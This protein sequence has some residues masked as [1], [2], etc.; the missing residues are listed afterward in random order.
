MPIIQLMCVIVMMVMLVI[1]AFCVPATNLKRI[2]VFRR[3]RLCPDHS[4]QSEDELNH[5]A[6]FILGIWLVKVFP[7]ANGDQYDSSRR[8]NKSKPVGHNHDPH[9]GGYATSRD[10]KVGIWFGHYSGFGLAVLISAT[11]V[12]KHQ[13]HSL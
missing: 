7:N 2:E 13:G 9:W 1:E 10:Q 6:T 5:L 12:C 8:R 4:D 3:Y 11:L